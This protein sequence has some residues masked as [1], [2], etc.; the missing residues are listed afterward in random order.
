MS[1]KVDYKHMDDTQDK[2][3]VI[4]EQKGNPID[5]GCAENHVKKSIDYAY[6]ISPHKRIRVVKD[7]QW[8][9]IVFSKP[10]LEAVENNGLLPSLIFCGNLV[11]DSRLLMTMSGGRVRT[12]LLQKFHKEYSLFETKNAHYI[13]CG[14]GERKAVKPELVFIE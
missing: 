4:V 12:S 10:H 5:I 8:W 3:Q 9:D 6:S 2:Y 13:L 14:M 11:Y 7:W 1:S